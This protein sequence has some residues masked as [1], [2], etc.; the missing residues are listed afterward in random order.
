MLLSVRKILA[1][2]DPAG[3]PKKTGR[4]RGARGFLGVPDKS[5][6]PGV[7]LVPEFF[8]QN[9][10]PDLQQQMGAPTAPSHLKLSFAS[11]NPLRMV[12]RSWLPRTSNNRFNQA[13]WRDI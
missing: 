11:C 5:G 6:I 1:N 8:I 2:R 7:E 9:S 3:R 4:L 13:R 12:A 10:G